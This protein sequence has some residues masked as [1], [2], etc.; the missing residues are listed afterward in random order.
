MCA[1]VGLIRSRGGVDRALLD[2]MRDTMAHRGPDD[3]GSW[4]SADG[5]VGLGHRRLSIIDL[6]PAG[7]QPMTNEDG[8]I[9]LVFNGE[10]YNFPELR[11]ELLR[12]GHQMRS[13]TDSEVILHA[14][15]EWGTDAVRRLRGMFAFAL[16]DGPRRRLLL[17]RDRLG[18][19]PLFYRHE[20]GDLT[21]AS[22][23]K[24]F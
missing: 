9:W 17:A 14:Y 6:S 16:W 18:I 23:L 10:I 7:H 15:E 3:A 11:R 24:A 13:N 2:R 4:T 22:E 19:K 1:I 5:T 20:G 21:F 12:A 8:S